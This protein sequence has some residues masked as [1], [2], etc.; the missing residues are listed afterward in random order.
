MYWAGITQGLMWKEFTAEG[1]L[2][3]P[4]FLETVLQIVPMYHIRAFGG[5]VY[6]CGVFVMFYNCN[7]LYSRKFLNDPTGFH[8]CNFILHNIFDTPLVTLTP[9]CVRVSA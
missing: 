3:Y 5:I 8:Y 2:Q 4:L 1:Y 6:L 7:G 9:V